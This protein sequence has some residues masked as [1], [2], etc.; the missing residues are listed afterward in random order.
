MVIRRCELALYEPK[1]KSNLRELPAEQSN[2]C[3]NNSV[4]VDSRHMLYEKL[5]TMLCIGDM[6]GSSLIVVGNF[7]VP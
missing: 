5:F 1:M 2:F 7:L 4:R 6:N 3:Y